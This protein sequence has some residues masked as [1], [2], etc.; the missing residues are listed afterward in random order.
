MWPVELQIRFFLRLVNSK[1]TLVQHDIFMNTYHET[2]I[3][4]QEVYIGTCPR[5]A[6]PG[7]LVLLVAGLQ[8]PRAGR[9]WRVSNDW[10]GV[11]GGGNEWG[12][13]G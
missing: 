1:V 13:V 3:V 4:T 5:W 9:W 2:L 12:E 7:D 11:C 10:A 6:K 8:T